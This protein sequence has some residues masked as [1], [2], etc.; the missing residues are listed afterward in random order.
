MQTNGK[1]INPRPPP[2]AKNKQVLTWIPCIKMRYV[3][4]KVD[5]AEII[6]VRHI[7]DSR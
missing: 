5:R 2:Q 6:P 7:S 1:K 3:G 4:I